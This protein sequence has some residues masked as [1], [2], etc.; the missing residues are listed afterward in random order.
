MMGF[1]CSLIEAVQRRGVPRHRHFPS[2]LPEQ[3]NTDG[4]PDE[5]RRQADTFTIDPDRRLKDSHVV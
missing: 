3:T 5:L 1:P 4:S 2:S